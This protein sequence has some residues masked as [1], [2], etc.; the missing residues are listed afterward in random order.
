MKKHLSLITLSAA[1]ACGPMEAPDIGVTEDEVAGN[2]GSAVSR[3][4]NK[5]GIGKYRA[6]MYVGVGGGCTGTVI[7]PHVVLSAAHCGDTPGWIMYRDIGWLSVSAIYKNPS[8]ITQHRPDWWVALD[9]A[10]KAAGGR[11]DDWPAQHDQI[12]LFVPDLTAEVLAD[13]DIEPVAIDPYAGADQYRLVGVA[14]TPNADFRDHIANRFVPSNANTITSHPRDGYLR[15]DNTTAGFGTAT[16]G[17]SGGSTIGSLSFPWSFGSFEGPRFVVGT[18]QNP[19]DL[20]PMAYDP[21]I[22]M[23]PN[24]RLTVRLNSLWAKARANDIDGDGVPALC[25][26]DPYASNVTTNSCP[27]TF[28]WP[29]GTATIDRPQADLTCKP[30]YV[31]VGYE[32]RAGNLIDQLAVRCRAISCFSG[33]PAGCDEYTTD[34]F[35][36]NGGTAFVRL[37]PSDKVLTGIYG[38]DYTNGDTR[39][40][41]GRCTSYNTVRS[42]STSS[43]NYLYPYVGNQLGTQAAGSWKNGYCA[44]GEVMIGFDARSRDRRLVTGL[45]PVCIKA[46]E[47]TTYVGGSGGSQH[48]VACPDGYLATAVRAKAGTT[49]SGKTVVNALSLE[50]TPRADIESDGYTSNSDRFVVHGSAWDY[51]RAKYIPAMRETYYGRHEPSGMTRRTCQTSTAM[52]SSALTGLN[53]RSGALLD[54]VTSA[55]CRDTQ[56]GAYQSHAV[57]VGGTGGSL[58]YLR[59]PSTARYVKGLT[60]RSGWLTDGVSLVCTN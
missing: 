19:V 60:V 42:G 9:N 33:N 17:D 20:A 13:N 27:S 18:A 25:D 37:C 55:V 22:T 48:T 4:E 53:V 51:G 21:G 36:G 57:S 10:Q 38:K 29:N 15:R 26:A 14:S 35:G 7:A 16:S 1:L 39:Q 49:S 23:T 40:F 30:G 34:E 54:Q 11:Q 6:M 46:N 50:C 45:Q 2:G 43:S 8:L 41:L 3:E 44:P 59:C 58:K 56:T 52:R 5:A 31:A 24:Q 28:G 12:L 32:G 47:T